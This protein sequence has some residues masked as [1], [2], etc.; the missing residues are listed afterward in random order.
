MADYRQVTLSDPLG[1]LPDLILK[2]FGETGYQRT[3]VNRVVTTGRT[4]INVPKL[5]KRPGNFSYFNWTLSAGV[6]STEANLLDAYQELSDQRY[7]ENTD[8]HILLIDQYLPVRQ[9][10]DR[11]LVDGLNFSENGQVYGY[12]IFKVL[13]IISQSPRQFLAGHIEQISFDAEELPTVV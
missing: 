9:R 12:G 5:G 6:S 3:P 8:G 2:G 11:T 7:G 4:L 1:I 10:D 13:L